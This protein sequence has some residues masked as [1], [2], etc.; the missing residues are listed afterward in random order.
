MTLDSKREY[1]SQA[2]YSGWVRE[3]AQRRVSNVM[4]SLRQAFENSIHKEELEII[5]F[6]D[7]TAGQLANK[8]GR[9]PLILKPLLLASNIAARAIER[10]LG[11]RNLDTYNTKLSKDVALSIA[12]YIKPFLPD[13]LP[14]LTLAELDRV[15]FA[16]KEIRKLKGQWERLVVKSLNHYANLVFRK[17]KF[18]H[19]GQ[20]F[21]LD[22]A[23]KDKA[24]SIIHGIDIKRVEARRDIHKRTDEI[25]NKAVHFK[26][27][28]PGAS[29][30]AII[31]YPFIG[32]H[33]NVRERLQS[34]FVDSVVFA[35]A[36]AESI[37]NAVRF[38]L[39]KLGCLKSQL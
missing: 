13:S 22:A 16:D 27:V 37:D 23:A 28:Y 32:E 36:S 39:G 29:F 4:T 1:S 31:Y 24:G 7:V 9:Y 5:V 34:T 20:E 38:L 30:G 18:Q 14:L 17:S 21:E 6:S 12:G 10:D 33:G 26:A 11:V 35:G 15:M 8:I 25:A 19:N 3:D 2:D